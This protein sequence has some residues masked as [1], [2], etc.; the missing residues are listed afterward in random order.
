MAC[1][2]FHY[3]GRWVVIR[4]SCWPQRESVCDWERLRDPLR[5]QQL[6]LLMLCSVFWRLEAAAGGNSSLWIRASGS[7]P[8]HGEQS[9][10]QW[11][12]LLLIT[13]RL[14]QSPL[15]LH[16]DS[17]SH[18]WCVWPDWVLPWHW[19]NPVVVSGP[20][21]ANEAWPARILVWHGEK[22]DWESERMNQLRLKPRVVWHQFL[23]FTERSYKGF[24]IEMSLLKR[25]T[26]FRQKVIVHKYEQMK[27]LMKPLYLNET[28]VLKYVYMYACI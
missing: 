25:Q 18:A 8:S 17:S 10:T 22:R 4:G 3:Q 6:T 15:Q 2:S 7:G 24:F 5:W 11:G 14:S 27:A 1:M 9:L 16:S 13:A 23:T 20:L 19:W 26:R 21:W 12:P 28:T